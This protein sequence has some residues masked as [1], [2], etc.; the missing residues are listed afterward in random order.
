MWW[1]W[2]LLKTLNVLDSG[3]DGW[4]TEHTA[5]KVTPVYEQRDG[6]VTVAERMYAR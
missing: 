6:Y 5:G 4:L 2:P 3:D 1:C